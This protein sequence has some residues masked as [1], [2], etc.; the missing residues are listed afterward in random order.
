MSKHDRK[1]SRGAG[2]ERSPKQTGQAKT[3]APKTPGRSATAGAKA[4]HPGAGSGRRGAGRPDSDRSRTERPGAGDPR[5]AEAGRHGQGKSQQRPGPRR[6]TQRA[7]TANQLPG[8]GRPIDSLADLIQPLGTDG[9]KPEVSAELGAGSE[10]IMEGYRA[11]L[12]ALAGRPNVGKSSLVNR[13]VGQ[14]VSIVTHK[15]QTTRH[16]IAGVA[17]FPQGQLVLLDTPGIHR[18][19]G[20]ALNRQMNRTAEKTLADAD[21][22]LLV[23]EAGRWTQEDQ[24][25]LKRVVASGRPCF[26]VV[27]KVDRMANKEALLPFVQEHFSDPQ[28]KAVFMVSART[29]LGLDRLINELLQTLPESGPLYPLD[30]ISD[31]PVRFLCAELIR[32]QL[33]ERLHEELPYGLTV[34]V[35]QWEDQGNAVAIHA[36]I[37]VSRES[38]K[39]MVIGKAGQVLKQV[40]TAARQ[41]IEHLIEQRVMLHLWVRVREDW[42]DD[43]KALGQFGYVED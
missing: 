17:S 36:A 16:R 12:V 2:A 7:V 23:V 29:G 43:D 27:N 15:A 5:R 35:E 37:W 20:R 22:V 32:E 13:L 14:K 28:F 30:Q 26:A 21:A 11:G 1:T 42:S 31:R 39:G 4:G 19:A 25:V 9:Q 24:D 18:Q 33:M 34:T 8:A 40:G 3:G 38:H 41:E 6:Q 10:A